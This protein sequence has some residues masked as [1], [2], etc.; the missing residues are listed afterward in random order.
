[1]NLQ[2]PKGS[3][4]TAPAVNSFALRKN[5]ELNFYLNLAE[6]GRKDERAASAGRV[7][8]I[9]HDKGRNRP[10][11]GGG[12]TGDFYG[13][14]LTVAGRTVEKNIPTLVPRRF[15][16]ARFNISRPLSRLKITKRFDAADG[17]TSRV[18]DLGH[19]PACAFAMPRFPTT[20]RSVNL[21]PRSVLSAKRRFRARD[22][23]SHAAVLILC[24][25]S[26]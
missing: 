25:C 3:P 6:P 26:R 21:S 22:G 11:G 10:R 5:A 8:F 7:K 9:F 12:E 20:H 24:V 4:D 13:H 1:M 23:V 18:S 19:V 2:L 15:P 17:C 16:T 14:Y